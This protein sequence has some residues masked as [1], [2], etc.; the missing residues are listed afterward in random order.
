MRR[1]RLPAGWVCTQ[2][3]RGEALPVAILFMG[4]LFTILM[5]V[6]VIVVAMAR[7]AVQAAADAAVNAAQAAAPDA[8]ESEGVLAAQ[9]ALA[10]ANSSAAETRTPVVVVEADRGQ[11]QALV[12]GGTISPVFGGVEVSALSCGPLDD[13]TAASAL[14]SPEAWQC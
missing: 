3:E 12:F 5:G 1:S 9:I 2:E 8:R 4:V 13:I 11:V 6:H 10:A 7:T 14:S